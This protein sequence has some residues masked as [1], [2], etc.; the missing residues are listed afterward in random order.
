MDLLQDLAEK[1]DPELVQLLQRVQ[2]LEQD[3]QQQ[4]Q[5]QAGANTNIL[6]YYEFLSDYLYHHNEEALALLDKT[7]VPLFSNAHFPS[8]F[9]LLFHRWLFQSKNFSLSRYNLFLKGANRLFFRDVTNRQV[10]FRRV[11][12]VRWCYVCNFVV[13]QV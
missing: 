12:K 11:Y 13:Y 10:C 7:C 5:Q 6:Y 2:R 8:I 1:I 4:Q 9:A 3:V